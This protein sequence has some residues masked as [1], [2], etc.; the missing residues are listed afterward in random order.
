MNRPLIKYCGISSLED[1]RAASASQADY[2][3][4]IFAESKRRIDPKEATEWISETGLNGKK[5]AAVTV[6]PG[7]EE[8]LSIAETLPLSVIQF[9]GDEDPAFLAQIKK[10][11]GIDV[12]KAVSGGSSVLEEMAR[13]QSVCDGFVADSRTK[14]AYGGTG[15]TFDWN[16]VP[17]IVQ[18][19]KKYGKLC[20]IAGGIS[21][22]N[23]ERL[24]EYKPEGID[25]ASGIEENGKKSLEKIKQL[26]EKVRKH[27]NT[28]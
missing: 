6:N 23:I 15:K 5:L 21:Y 20:F 8:I 2:I 10:T 14:D 11:A 19:A 27:E 26:E 4:M 22:L 17:A 28:A 7:E 18:E 12:W 9:H 13:Y 25:L 24:M 1:L 16:L 3:G